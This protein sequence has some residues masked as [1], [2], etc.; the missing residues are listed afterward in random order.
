[1]HEAIEEV[2]LASQSECCLSCQGV[3]EATDDELL[4]QVRDIFGIFEAVPIC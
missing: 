2:K 4:G 3:D 1:M